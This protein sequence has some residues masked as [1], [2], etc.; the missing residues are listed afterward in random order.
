MTLRAGNCYFLY[1]FFYFLSEYKAFFITAVLLRTS[2]S[3]TLTLPWRSGTAFYHFM[4][5][6][7]L[8]WVFLLFL[9]PFTP[10]SLSL[11][12]CLQPKQPYCFH[13]HRFPALTSIPWIL[14]QVKV[15]NQGGIYP[16]FPFALHTLLLSTGMWAAPCLASQLLN[17]TR[18]N[19]GGLYSG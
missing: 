4:S 6:P 2:Q 1:F 5:S 10:S 3:G 19:S 16:E 12:F 17:N 8:G 14:Q 11:R 15:R 9:S 7:K 18:T 13:S